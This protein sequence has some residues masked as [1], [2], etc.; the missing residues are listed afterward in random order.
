MAFHE[1][2]D[3][4][5]KRAKRGVES[6]IPFGLAASR[7]RRIFHAPMVRNGLSRPDRTDLARRL[8]A[9]RDDE[10]ELD[11]CGCSKFIPT[12]A[13][14]ADRGNL[15]LREQLERERIHAAGWM[16]ASAAR[17]KASVAPVIQHRL[18]KN[19]PRRIAGAQEKH[20]VRALRFPS[21]HRNEHYAE[22]VTYGTGLQDV[23]YDRNFRLHKRLSSRRLIAGSAIIGSIGTFS[24]HVL[25]P[26]LPAIADAM[27]VPDAAAQLLISLSIVAIALGNLTVA[28]LSDRYG[29][30]QV[31]LFS[32]GLFVIGSAAGI[33]APSLELLVLSRVLQAFGGGAAMS[34]M[35][36]TILDHFGPTRAPGALAATATAILVAPMIAPTLGGIAIEWLDWRAVFALSGLLGF[37]VFLFASRNLRK[38]RPPDPA[39]GPSLPYWSSYRRLLSSREYVA[40]L[41][42]G[43][44]MVSMIYTFVT[45]APYVAIDVLGVSP[46]RFG[47]LLFLPAVASFSGFLIAARITSR[48]G[49]QRMMRIG[50]MIA[51][52]GSLSMAAL[53]LAG[54]W[55]PLALFVPGMMLGFANAI[56]APSSTI[57][58]IS[59]DPA[60]AG[61]ASGLLGFLQLVT[62]AA[63]T[64]LVAAF[65]GHSPVPLAV[66]L[67]GLC[68]VALLALRPI[69]RISLQ[70]E[71][72]PV[73]TE[74]TR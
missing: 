62:A 30:R 46:A 8:V 5:L 43:S 24:L 53:T 23:D 14:R 21:R 36:A 67:L 32:L 72:P 6:L 59:R 33:V 70:A 66:V 31:V 19:A 55:H 45:G 40:F 52:A 34:V 64:Q 50:A 58:A 74:P 7:C 37:G 25:L 3:A 38:T 56:A 71:P 57:G 54:I 18:G 4:L 13:P 39:A 11:A 12:L 27:R 29:R 63:A 42:F 68:L 10:V 44:C 69:G 15:L 60:I 17:A 73:M 65:T 1:A 35:R 48:I 41:V 61:T 51:F 47:L 20:V 49:G 26:A 9:N 28:P 16:A 22:R 2:P